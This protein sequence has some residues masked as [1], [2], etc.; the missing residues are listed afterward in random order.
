MVPNPFRYTVRFEAPGSYRVLFRT[1]GWIE[2]A[3]PVGFGPSETFTS[4][5]PPRPWQ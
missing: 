3:Q 2:G 4:T 1:G 5:C